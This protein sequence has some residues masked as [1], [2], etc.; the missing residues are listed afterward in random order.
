MKVKNL[1]ESLQDCG[2]GSTWL[3]YGNVPLVYISKVS[4]GH[5]YKL[6]QDESCEFYN[7]VGLEFFSSG[8][9]IILTSYHNKDE[10]AVDNNTIEIMDA[11]SQNIIKLLQQLNPKGDLEVLCDDK[12]IYF[13]EG[14]PYYY[15]GRLNEL[16]RD[17]SGKIVSI[18]ESNNPF[19]LRV[20]T[21]SYED[22][23]DPYKIGNN[24]FQIKY[25]DEK[26]KEYYQPLVENEIQRAINMQQK[27]YV[28]SFVRFIKNK[29]QDSNEWKENQILLEKEATEWANNNL[30]YTDPMP[31]LNI[32]VNLS[33]E[34][35]QHRLWDARLNVVIENGQLKITNKL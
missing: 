29:F 15:D 6:I 16:V 19:K 12:T 30:K 14:L 10:I 22:A 18:V 33:I 2:D 35:R 4:D 31:V 5:Y 1:I 26:A 21:I 32:G 9:R 11:S 8:E 25:T 13:V 20:N 7:V 28:E 27:F 34:D 24:K 23:I 3:V 17:G